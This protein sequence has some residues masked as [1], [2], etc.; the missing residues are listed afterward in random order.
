MEIQLIYMQF[1]KDYQ[2][3]VGMEMTVAEMGGMVT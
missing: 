2:G 3:L 1:D